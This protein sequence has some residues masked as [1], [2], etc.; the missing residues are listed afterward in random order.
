MNILF[1]K[2]SRNFL[3]LLGLL[4][5]PT[6]AAAQS[7]ITGQAIDQAT[8]AGVSY[9]TLVVKTNGPDGSVVNSALADENGR[10][11]LQGL[12]PG[13]YQFNILMLNYA[14]HVQAL[15]LLAGA[16]PLSLAPIGLQAAA[17]QLAEVQVVGQRPLLE[18]KPDRITMNVAHSVLAAGNDG[19]SILAMAPAVQLRDGHLTF[20]GKSN[21]LILLNGKRLPGANLESVLASLPGDQIERIELISNPSSKYDANASGGVIEIYTK[22]S[23]E[24]GWAANLGGNLSQGFRMGQGLNGGV[25]ASSAKFDFAANGSLANRNGIERGYENRTFFAGRTPAGTLH[26]DNDF[27]TTIRDGSFAGSV[28]YH[29][30]ERTTVGVDVQTVTSSIAAQGLLQGVIREAGGITNSTSRNNGRVAIDLRS[31]NLFFQRTLDKQGS[32]LLGTANYAQ[33][34]SRQEQTFNQYQQGFRDSTGSESVFRNTAPATYDIY[35][36]ALDYTKVLGPTTRLEAGLKYTAT[37]NDSRQQA[38]LLT[39]GQWKPQA[40]TPFS[41][42][43]YQEQIGAGYFSL[44]KTYDKLTL[45]AGLRAEQTRYQVRAGIDSS[46]FNLFPNLRADFKASPNY[47]TSLAYARNVNRPAYE[48]LIPYE[49]FINNYTSRKGNAR[50]RPEY[51]NSFSWNH[52]Y[53]GFGLQ[54]AYTQTTNAIASLYVYQPATL[55]FVLTPQNFRQR[56]LGTITLT[57]PVQLAKWWS[58]TNNSSLLYQQLSLPDPMETAAIYTKQKVYFTA[59]TDHTFQLGHDWTAQVFGAYGSP[60]FSGLLDYSSYSNVRVAVK[61][62]LLQKHASLKLEVMD[63]FYQANVGISSNVVPI[64][65][66][67]INRTDTRRVRASFTYNFGKTGF[68]SKQVQTKGNTDEL[69]RLH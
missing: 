36:S 7:T 17:Q 57:A 66:E 52:L 16:P 55:R 18:Q 45:A 2:K 63:I 56:H 50:L 23:P 14:T 44:N 39:E 27:E 60:S 64:V 32:S 15:N 29:F 33:F 31:Y 62:S 21:V 13:I 40:T 67:G 54:L 6:L 65:T 22:R 30:D 48:N 4:A 51:T 28:N 69:N 24:G 3:T 47:T 5:G 42:L 19:Y 10:F 11:T 1:N 38:E 59:S 58:M 49:L 53:K 8:Q 35:T 26:Q 9:A 25:R 46:Y 37:Y 12:K 20:R 61:K 68:K 41:H 43:G 34:L